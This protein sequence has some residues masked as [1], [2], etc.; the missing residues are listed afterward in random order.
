MTDSLY[1]DINNSTTID[2]NSYLLFVHMHKQC[3]VLITIESDSVSGVNKVLI[4]FD[5]SHKYIMY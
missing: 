1:I 4:I 2:G 3:T 5:E